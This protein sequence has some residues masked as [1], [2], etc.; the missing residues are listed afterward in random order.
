MG[1]VIANGSFTLVG[2]VA[3]LSILR[4]TG[5]STESLYGF[6]GDCLSLVDKP[7]KIPTRTDMPN[8]SY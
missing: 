1:G 6:P 7:N 2:R 5:K 4:A 8:T 3:V